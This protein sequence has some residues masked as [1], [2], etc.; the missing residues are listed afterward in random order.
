[1]RDAAPRPLP[2]EDW[3]RQV[4]RA[5]GGVMTEGRDAHTIVI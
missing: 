1:M 2:V 4:F 5:P 3:L